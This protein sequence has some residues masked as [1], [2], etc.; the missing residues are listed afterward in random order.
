MMTMTGK[1]KI[2]EGF[3]A[4]TFHLRRDLDDDLRFE[5]LASTE[6]VQ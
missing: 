6:G 2:R 3:V 1:D 5:A 4:H